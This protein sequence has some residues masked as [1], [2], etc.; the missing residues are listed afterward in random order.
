M[1]HGSAAA[2]LPPLTPELGLPP[3]L[4]R[5]LA[6]S[7]VQFVHA[8]VALM[9]AGPKPVAVAA[10]AL[11]PVA[12]G[13]ASFGTETAPADL[14]PAGAGVYKVGNVISLMSDFV[15]H[16]LPDRSLEIV[17]ALKS[18]ISVGQVMSSLDDYRAL[19][20]P[21]DDADHQ[22]LAEPQRMLDSA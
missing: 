18:L 8:G 10:L 7:P 17:L 3:T 9:Q 13:F 21:I 5:D 12:D 6:G 14:R 4:S 15:T 20:S 22:H 11:T 16:H 1:R 2:G 19:I